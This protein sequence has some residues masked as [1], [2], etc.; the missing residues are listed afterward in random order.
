MRTELREVSS[1]GRQT[2]RLAGI[3]SLIVF[4]C[5]PTLTAE[6]TST[7]STPSPIVEPMPSPF[8][9]EGEAFVFRAPRGQTE[10]LRWDLDDVVPGELYSVSFFFQNH[11]MRDPRELEA[12]AFSIGDSDRRIYH[13]RLY[14]RNHPQF[15]STDVVFESNQGVVLITIKPG[16]EIV[17]GDFGRVVEVDDLTHIRSPHSSLL[18]PPSLRLPDIYR[19]LR[20][21][22]IDVALWSGEPGTVAKLDSVEV[23]AGMNMTAAKLPQ[24]LPGKNTLRI[25]RDQA[26]S[27]AKLT[28][29]I[30]P[31]SSAGS[32]E[33]AVVFDQRVPADG[34][35]FGRVIISAFDHDGTAVSGSF[36][37]LRPPPEV[38]AHPYVRAISDWQ[39]LQTSREFHLTSLTP[40]VHRIGVERWNG[41]SWE[42]TA[43]AFE[44][45][46]EEGSPPA[47]N[48]L[49]SDYARRWLEPLPA[50][51]QVDRIDRLEL[52][53]AEKTGSD[54]IQFAVDSEL[55]PQ[56]SWRIQGPVEGLG[57]HADFQPNSRTLAETAQSLRQIF[58]RDSESPD[59]DFALGV[60]EYVGLNTEG[61]LP[62]FFNTLDYQ[63]Y[64]RLHR[65]GRG[66]CNQFAR[67]TH[68]L[69]IEGGLES[70]LRNTP[71]HVMGEVRSEDLEIM[72]VDSMLQVAVTDTDGN[73][74][75][76]DELEIEDFRIIGA[77]V[78][79]R[80]RRGSFSG[81]LVSPLPV[82]TPWSR[83]DREDIAYRNAVLDDRIFSIDLEP[84]E[85]LTWSSGSVPGEG[86][87]AS[88][89]RVAEN[90]TILTKTSRIT[91]P[92]F[93]DDPAVGFDRIARSEF[94]SLKSATDGWGRISFNFQ[95]PV[96]VDNLIVITDGMLGGGGRIAISVRPKLHPP[97]VVGPEGFELQ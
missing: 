34:A 46:F 92:A 54:E 69:M 82:Q 71:D 1:F 7:D 67:A 88:H 70:R 6:T 61:V 52:T 11:R 64:G 87:H 17:F 28:A 65:E 2:I 75:T 74:A 38:K 22:D 4:S 57:I 36:L 13:Q 48:F 59:R 24:I 72:F 15:F 10:T 81:Y 76:L 12:F 21:F 80:T 53:W 5:L 86:M 40:G 25:V 33:L 26:G 79:D 39:T 14:G 68:A 18:W 35:T 29:E 90:Q 9:R 66:W 94:G 20:N 30:T 85:E 89:R 23:R 45:T 58:T 16:F 31:R 63:T 95:T 55:A 37:R 42:N 77:D 97:L 49:R 78:D 96:E 27:A 60:E 83:R 93:S 43:T 32:P 3:M 8:A 47:A 73:R 84:W 50:D 51:E 91:F 56:I 19:G 41:R 44:V 62:D